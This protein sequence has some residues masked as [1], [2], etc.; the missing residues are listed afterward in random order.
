MLPNS[1]TVHPDVTLL[2]LTQEWLLMEWRHI[3]RRRWR[4][5]EV[6]YVRKETLDQWTTISQQYMVTVL[7]DGSTLQYSSWFRAGFLHKS[8]IAAS[9]AAPVSRP[10]ASSPDIRKHMVHMKPNP[11][12]TTLASPR[13]DSMQ[14]NGAGEQP[15]GINKT[16][17]ASRSSSTNWLSQMANRASRKSTSVIT[18]G[19]ISKKPRTK[20]GMSDIPGGGRNPGQSTTMARA[21][22]RSPSI[23]DRSPDG[24]RLMEPSDE[25]ASRQ[26]STSDT[27]SCRSSNSTQSGVDGPH[28]RAQ[29]RNE[30]NTA[31]LMKK[32]R[33]EREEDS[34]DSR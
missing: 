2:M 34:L 15:P 9:L 10:L 14:G 17:T 30:E 3:L 20:Q 23:E 32:R 31:A 13:V 5:C 19:R 4:I 1:P 11:K 24:S 22:L 21:S 25:Q 33:L 7:I 18:E 12:G 26:S 28:E 6:L 29:P 16:S 8:E 27:L